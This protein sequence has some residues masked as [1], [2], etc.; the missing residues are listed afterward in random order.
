MSHRTSMN[1]QQAWDASQKVLRYM[2]G[3]GIL[4]E[5]EKVEHFLQICDFTGIHYDRA[6]LQMDFPHILDRQRF[7]R[8]MPGY[9]QCDYIRNLDSWRKS[10]NKNDAR[11]VALLMPGVS[12]FERSVNKH[13][14]SSRDGNWFAWWD[15]YGRYQS[16]EISANDSLERQERLDLDWYVLEFLFP[17]SG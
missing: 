17:S 14:W 10:L 13:L 6:Q 5:E 4:T 3:I 15:N 7:F 9:L 8:N 11:Y 1:S 2:T 16:L 12:V